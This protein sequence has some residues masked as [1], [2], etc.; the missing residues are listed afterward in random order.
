MTVDSRVTDRP[1]QSVAQQAFGPK[2]YTAMDNY[3]RTGN[4]DALISSVSSIVRERM[5]DAEYT[6]EQII[7]ITAEIDFLHQNAKMIPA[8]DF[9]YKSIVNS[10]WEERDPEAGEKN[11]IQPLVYEVICLTL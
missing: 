10:G 5:P 7:E 3:N 2:A 8:S 9:G 4:S 11:E 6:P 1:L